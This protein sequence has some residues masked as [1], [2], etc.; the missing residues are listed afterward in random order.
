MAI[1]VSERLV[2]P[3]LPISAEVNHFAGAVMKMSDFDFVKVKAVG[4]QRTKW[5]RES[6]S[7]IVAEGIELALWQ[8]TRACERGT[9][10]LS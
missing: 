6:R 10:S 1:F 9:R 5:F 4:M 2:K 7:Y 3:S 8:F